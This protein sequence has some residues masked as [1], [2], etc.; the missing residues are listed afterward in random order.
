MS[1]WRSMHAGGVRR[2]RDRSAGP[3]PLAR[4]NMPA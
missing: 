4:R 1:R 3:G 2:S